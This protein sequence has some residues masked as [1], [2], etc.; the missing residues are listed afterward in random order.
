MLEENYAY[1]FENI[2]GTDEINIS[3]GNLGMSWFWVFPP[4]FIARMRHENGK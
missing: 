2:V 3:E 1:R 4:S